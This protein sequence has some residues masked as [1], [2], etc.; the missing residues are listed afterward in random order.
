MG[1]AFELRQRPSGNVSAVAGPEW[2]NQVHHC[3]SSD[4]S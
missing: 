2:I 3:L 1:I 4:G